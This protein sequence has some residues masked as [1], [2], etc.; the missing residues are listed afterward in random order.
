[1]DFY[2]QQYA[3]AVIFSGHPLTRKMM[4]KFTINADDITV[5]NPPGHLDFFTLEAHVRFV[6]TGSGGLLEE[7]C[8]LK[9]P[10]VTLRE[11]TGRPETVRRRYKHA[12]GC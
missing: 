11:D 10:C 2:S 5:M 1:M 9:V 3:P 7:S 4:Q 12:C 6:L 8:I